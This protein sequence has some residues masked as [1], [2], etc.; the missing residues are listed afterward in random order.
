MGVIIAG[1]RG[2]GDSMSVWLLVHAQAL[3][4]RG[5]PLRRPRKRGHSAPAAPAAFAVSQEEHPQRL[6]GDADDG[7][8]VGCG[9]ARTLL[10]GYLSTGGW[11][12]KRCP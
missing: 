2:P 4:R 7:W 3:S 1:A 10:E 9:E 6:G 8:G 12:S 11:R 5:W